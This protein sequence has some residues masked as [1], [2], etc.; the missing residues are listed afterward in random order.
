VN[1]NSIGFNSIWTS[2]ICKLPDQPDRLGTILAAVSIYVL[3]L[4]SKRLRDRALLRH[5][6]N[7]LEQDTSVA[8]INADKELALDKRENDLD[9]L[10]FINEAWKDSISRITAMETDMGSLRGQMNALQRERDAEATGHAA[11]RAEIEVVRQQMTSLNGRVE[12]LASQVKA[13]GCDPVP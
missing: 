5:K 8:R 3:G 12:R 11:C 2:E 7:Q 13:L 1:E 9:T 4:F 6:A 10:K